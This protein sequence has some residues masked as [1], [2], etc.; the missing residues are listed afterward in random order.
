MTKSKVMC[1][2]GKE[3]SPI[4]IK[5]SE[6]KPCNLN[7]NLTFYYRSSSCFLK[8][9]DKDIILDYD[10]GSHVIYDNNVYE[11]DI[12][13][14]TLPS[15]HKINGKN[16]S[17]EMQLYHTSPDIGKKLVISIM[18]DINDAYSK[19]K[20]FFEMLSNNL[21]KY[22]GEEKF[23]NTSDEWN[24]YNAIPESK[25]FYTY[26]GSIL[27]HPCSEG[28][29]WIVFDT[30]VNMSDRTFYNI[31]KVT[32]FNSK[33]VQRLN[34]RQVYYN[35]NSGTKSVRNYGNRL[36]CYTDKELRDACNCMAKKPTNL[37]IHKTIKTALFIL[38]CTFIAM[39]A[40][41][42]LVYGKERLRKIGAYLNN[43]R[44]F[45]SSL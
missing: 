37:S 34:G 22:S 2:K 21:P 9:M 3:Q 4:D 35:L 25:S 14:F 33:N 16:Y 28:V 11:L 7:C 12:V 6:A 38:I 20:T 13:S 32:G 45:Q 36:R 26:S 40:L 31:K 1:D 19:S 5:T 27:K 10:A 41:I 43:L 30:P 23:Y 39:F 17:G 15:S 42:G 44:P 24:I 29:T 18:I 8:N